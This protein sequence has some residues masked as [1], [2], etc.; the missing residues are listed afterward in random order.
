MDMTFKTTSGALALAPGMDAGVPCRWPNAPGLQAPAAVFSVEERREYLTRFGWRSNSYF[1]LQEGVDYFDVPGA[2]F[3]A[4]YRQRGL[5]GEVPIVFTRPICASS[6]MERL[7]RF[8]LDR[9][10]ERAVFVGIDE[11]VAGI[12]RGFGFTTNVAST[13]F[14]IPLQEFTLKG[15]DRKYLRHAHN[16]CEKVIDVREL[17][18]AQTDPKAVME[19]SNAWRQS[20]AVKGRE[21]RLTTRP[22]E[23][24]DRWGVRRFYAFKEG[25]L[26]GFVFFDPFFRD[27]RIIGYTA[28]ILRSKPGLKPHG[29]LDYVILRAIEQFRAEGLEV[30]SLGQSPLHGIAPCEGESRSLRRFAELIYQW[31]SHFYASKELGFHK[32]LYR[33]REEKAYLAKRGV[34]TLGTVWLLL[35][36]TNAL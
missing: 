2:G 19:I 16:S 32:A 22:P 6:D 9:H 33:A 15:R 34:G 18:Y 30:F 24:V 17:A 4:Y 11:E 10:G 5:R 1:C 7:I 21:L 12:L 26:V 20:K 29:V 23:F 3:I 36:A 13:E 28:N 8:F 35:R 27:G 25:E 31:G 14:D